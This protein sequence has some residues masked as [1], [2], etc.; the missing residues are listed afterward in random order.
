LYELII[1]KDRL[2]ETK[3]IEV[4]QYL[5]AKYLETP[6]VKTDASEDKK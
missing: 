5:S 3:R 6:V 1:F 2:S 4:E